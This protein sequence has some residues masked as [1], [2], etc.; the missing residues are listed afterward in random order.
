M[1]SHITSLALYLLAI[2]LCS[3]SPSDAQSNS[4]SA[5][6]AQK[7]VPTHSP[8]SVI[9]AAE[10]R[11]ST[12]GT[13]DTK[14]TVR[15]CT[16]AIRLGK[17][18]GPRLASALSSRAQA[19]FTGRAYDLAIQ[20]YKQ[21]IRLKPTDGGLHLDLGEAL[22]QKHD[23]PGA[24]AQFREAVHLSP[25]DA[26][27]R[28]ALG[29]A[30]LQQ[31]DAEGA[32]GEYRAAAKLD[33]TNPTYH[34][35]LGDALLKTRDFQATL[36][37][38]LRGLQIMPQLS[39]VQ[40]AA[41]GNFLFR[42]GDLN[43]SIEQYRKAV[44]LS[45]EDVQIHTGLAAAYARK[46]DAGAEIDQYR[47][48]ARLSPKDLAN[49]NRLAAALMSQKDYANAKSE[50]GEVLR[51]SPNNAAAYAGMG[52]A[53]AGLGNFDAANT[54][55]QQA[56]RIDPQNTF[57]QSTLN[58]V[59]QWQAETSQQAQAATQSQNTAS[60]NTW[61]SDFDQIRDQEMQNTLRV[62]WRQKIQQSGEAIPQLISQMQ[63]TSAQL[64]AHLEQVQQAIEATAAE[65]VTSFDFNFDYEATCKNNPDKDVLLA[66]EC[67]Y[68]NTQNALHG[69]DGTLQI[70]N[71]MGSFSPAPSNEV[72]PTGA[73]LATYTPGGKDIAVCKEDTGSHVYTPGS[74]EKQ[75][76]CSTSTSAGMLDTQGNLKSA[77]VGM[78]SDYSAVVEQGRSS[79]DATIHATLLSSQLSGEG[80]SLQ[81]Q[82]GVQPNPSSASVP[83][84]CFELE[85]TIE[86]IQRKVDGSPGPAAGQTYHTKFASASDTAQIE[87]PVASTG[88]NDIDLTGWQVSGALCHPSDHCTSPEECAQLEDYK[89][90]ELPNQMM[91]LIKSYGIT[92]LNRE[93][94][95]NLQADLNQQVSDINDAVFL[96][97]L[98]IIVDEINDLAPIFAPQ[99]KL[100]NLAVILGPKP[101]LASRDVMEFI[102]EPQKQ[103]LDAK[104]A[105]EQAVNNDY[106]GLLWS[107]GAHYFSTVA[108]VKDI[109][110]DA[111][112][113]HDLRAL[114]GPQRARVPHRRTANTD[115][116]QG[117]LRRQ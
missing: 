14:A 115:Q 18:P 12:T 26:T 58:E 46:G 94:A 34:F 104:E 17:L 9:N 108:L 107:I 21:A 63:Q 89:T 60:C 41:L 23:L 90:N 100:A 25:G 62:D 3:A 42:R 95:A 59:S 56:V 53:E 35:A 97:H 36:A 113:I 87:L 47:E 98:K 106:I 96:D 84:G 28:S 24:I 66:A 64:Q 40:H 30:L 55:L 92:D 72:Q 44:Q 13:N 31:G 48:I 57:A 70:L 93:A 68:V 103:L 86:A 39:S 54:D 80:A 4:H 27:A 20:D 32:L 1:R 85:Y 15:Y 67:E 78:T 101:S 51:L 82:V 111:T 29:E 71:C 83:G 116:R 69:A 22:L 52:A 77:F 2:L 61:P 81:F 114:G 117:P 49:H 105:L 33:D 45:P 88:S 74:A 75:D 8:G 65:P 109:M 99:G 16:E 10:R 6:A 7:S 50:Y 11:C 112:Q 5:C 102:V 19:Y 38:W 37:E 73:P 79:C 110:N 43:G 76:S 91:D